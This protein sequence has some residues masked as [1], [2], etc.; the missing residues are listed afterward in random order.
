MR[1]LTETVYL[2]NHNAGVLRETHKEQKSSVEQK[3]KSF[4]DFNFQ[5]EYKLWKCGLLIL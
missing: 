2:L 1:S 5:Y 3:S 4:F